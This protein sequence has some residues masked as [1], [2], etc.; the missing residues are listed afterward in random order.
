MLENNIFPVSNIFCYGQVKSDYGSGQFK[1]DLD[2]HFGREDGRIITSEIR[3]REGIYD[4]I[5][6][7]LGKGK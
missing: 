5:R 4:S 1:K 7:F 2:E 3:D 6:E